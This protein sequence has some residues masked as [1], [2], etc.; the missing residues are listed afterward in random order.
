M[1]ELLK[2]NDVVLISYATALLAGENI[3]HTVFDTNMSVLEGSI[4]ILPKR[5]MV[6]PERLDEARELMHAAGVMPC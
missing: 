3:A 2:T 4:G 1:T 5:L 6:D